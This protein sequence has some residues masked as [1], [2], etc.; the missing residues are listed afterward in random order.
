[1]RHFKAFLAIIYIAIVLVGCDPQKRAARRANRLVSRAMVINPD[2][3]RDT[4]LSLDVEVATPERRAVGQFP[5]EFDRP[6]VTE[7]D[8]VVTTVMVTQDSIYTNTIVE[9]DTSTV[10]KDVEVP[11]IVKTRDSGSNGGF[12]R[13]I[14]RVIWLVIALVIVILVVNLT[15]K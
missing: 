2:M 12:F 6:F 4:L 10:R 1:M 8:G 14:E 15:R 13:N 7:Q 9:A 3:F 11:V 5:L